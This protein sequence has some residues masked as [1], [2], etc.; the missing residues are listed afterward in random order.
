MSIS[1]AWEAAGSATGHP[2]LAAG[3]SWLLPG[4]G[5]LYCR[6][7]VR[8]IGVFLLFCLSGAILGALLISSYLPD[9][10]AV[11]LSFLIP[12]LLRAGASAD[13][14]RTARRLYSVDIE[15]M[16]GPAQRAYFPVFLSALVPGLG[17]LHERRWRSKI[18]FLFLSLYLWLV[19]VS[20]ASL[21]GKAG[22]M[23]LRSLACA[24]AFLM[25][26]HERD[27]RAW[28]A[29]WL[30][31]GIV[32]AT[33]VGSYTL[34]A[35]RRSFL[36]ENLLWNGNSMMPTVPRGSHCIADMM[37]Y[38]Y[39]DPEIGDIIL[40]TS[41]KS[42]VDKGKGRQI[43]LS[44]I[45]ARGGETV[46]VRN[47]VIFVNG[48]HREP[49]A[50]RWLHSFFSPE[51]VNWEASWLSYGVAQPYSVPDGCYFVLSDDRTTGDDSRHYGPVPRK[52]IVGRITRIY[53]R[54]RQARLVRLPGSKRSSDPEIFTPRGT[55][56]PPS[57]A[58]LRDFLKSYKEGKWRTEGRPSKAPAQEKGGDRGQP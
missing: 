39:R 40:F 4:A 9:G 5:H 6:A 50:E 30:V 48:E 12:K 33:L 41:P 31:A 51:V 38:R 10:L 37:T 56:S 53:W 20:F 28:R 32:A 7:Y 47:G 34:R 58:Q 16:R 46:R 42:G 18:G 24:H 14:F 57:D 35:T 15:S 36:V 22:V 43:R 17:Q 3:L 44:R 1:E 52:N 8:G 45:V 54:P 27:N 13:A 25:G 19:P 2:W 23:I 26:T 21:V 29:A 11:G 49:A 55:E